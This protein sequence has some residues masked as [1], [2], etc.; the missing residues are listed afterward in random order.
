M[1]EKK[2]YYKCFLLEANLEMNSLSCN[3]LQNKGIMHLPAFTQKSPIMAS[4]FDEGVCVKQLR[5][6]ASLFLRAA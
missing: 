3:L 2:T 4:G 1:D 6:K 5:I